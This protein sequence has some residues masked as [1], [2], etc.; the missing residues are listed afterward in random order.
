MPWAFLLEP[1]KAAAFVA[2]VVVARL[3]SHTKF[4]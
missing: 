4:A 3:H 1:F 2:L